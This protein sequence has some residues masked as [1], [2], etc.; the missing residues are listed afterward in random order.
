MKLFYSTLVLMLA[1]AGLSA[2]GSPGGT[3][4]AVGAAAGAGYIVAD[5][6]NEGDGEFDVLEDARGE[7]NGRN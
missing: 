6:V 7:G 5:E 2:C 3:A 4:A 1:A